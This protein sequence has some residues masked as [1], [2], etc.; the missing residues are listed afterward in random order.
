[1]TQVKQEPI[2]INAEDLDLYEDKVVDVEFEAK[3][4]FIINELEE[5]AH[6]KINR[7]NNHLEVYINTVRSLKRP[8]NEELFDGFIR[9]IKRTRITLNELHNKIL[10]DNFFDEDEPL[11]I[12]E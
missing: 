10:S 3:D 4:A 8:H 1:M 12:E 11:V 7:I 9:D 6:D 5:F 2:I